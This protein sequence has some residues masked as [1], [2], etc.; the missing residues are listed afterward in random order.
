[1]IERLARAKVNLALAVIGR[2]PDGYH[3]LVSVFAR[4]DLADRLAVEPS[5]DGDRLVVTGGS[6]DYTPGA[7]DLVLRAAV[8]LR[9]ARAPGAPGLAFRLEKDVPLAAGLGGG[10]ADGAAALDLAARAWSIELGADERLALAARLGSDVPFLVADADTALVT[11]RGERVERLPGPLDPTGVLLVTAGDGLSTRDVFGALAADPDAVGDPGAG[12]GS[13]A[14]DRARNLAASLAAGCRAADL[15]AM[16]RDLRDANDLWPAT[17]RLRPDLADLRLALEARLGRP[18]LLSG[19]GPTLL[20]LYPSR[21]A[22]ETAATALR[23]DPTPG[24]DAA[25]VRAATFERTTTLEER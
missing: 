5:G 3:D 12:T 23:T 15:V 25:A 6:I 17:S 4:L 21:V 20:A 9:Q 1:L 24:L 13:V 7:D 14:A 19:S 2:R 11:G 10:S 16:A 18:V 22:A 8:L